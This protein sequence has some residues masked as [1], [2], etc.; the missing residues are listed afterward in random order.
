M[1]T[2]PASTAKAGTASTATQ[3]PEITSEQEYQTMFS[4]V[5]ML[6]AKGDNLTQEERTEFEKKNML[7]RQWENDNVKQNN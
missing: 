7:L 6:K 3:Y 5:E 2:N 1:E 4:Q